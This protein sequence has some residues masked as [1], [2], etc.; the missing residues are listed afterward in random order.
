MASLAHDLMPLSPP[1][2]EAVQGKLAAEIEKRYRSENEA[3]GLRV[4]LSAVEGRLRSL[5][6]SSA[7]REAII[8]AQ[9]AIIAARHGE[10]PTWERRQLAL[11]S[12]LSN[13]RGMVSQVWVNLGFVASHADEPETRTQIRYQRDALASVMTW[14][15]A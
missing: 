11:E 1:E 5:E 4:Q 14:V 13:L 7:K 2:E 6:A 12:E 15:E 3:A 10:D 9:G 8:Q